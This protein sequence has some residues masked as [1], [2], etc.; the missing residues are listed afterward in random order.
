M[1][2]ESKDRWIDCGNENNEAIE[3]GLPGRFTIA[4]QTAALSSALTG[5][6]H[7]IMGGSD[8]TTESP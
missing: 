4:T 1:T 6:C 8:R 2:V 5:G 3:L 7:K